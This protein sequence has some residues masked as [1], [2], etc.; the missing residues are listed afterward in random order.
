MGLMSVRAIAN[1]LEGKPVTGLIAP[2]E[3]I[4]TSDNLGDSRSEHLLGINV[5]E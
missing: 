5:R 1:S 3:H 2:D 4:L